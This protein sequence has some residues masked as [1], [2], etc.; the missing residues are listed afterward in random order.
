M[1]TTDLGDPFR[2]PASRYTMS[3]HR[4][5]AVCA[6]LSENH[7]T[8]TEDQAETARRRSAA[9]RS[10]APPRSSS[11]SSPA[12]SGSQFVIPD[13]QFTIAPRARCV[14]SSGPRADGAGKT[15]LRH[16]G[17]H[18]LCSL[19]GAPLFLLLFLPA[20]LADTCGTEP[21]CPAC[22]ADFALYDPVYEDDGVWEEEVTALEAMFTA[23]GWTWRP[24][25]PADINGG[26]LGT[27]D[28]R[29]YRALIA[30]GGY[31]YPRDRDISEAGEEAL[32]SFVSSGGNYVGFCAGTYWTADQVEWAET[33]TG[34][35]GTYNQASDYA[36]YPYHL[37]L[38]PGVARGP[39][40]WSPWMAGTNPSLEAYAIN[41]DNDTLSHIGMPPA[42]RF[43]YYG[44][45]VF[46]G[47]DP[48]PD[49]YEVWATAVKPAGTE[50]AASGGDGEPAIIRYTYGTG[51]V[52]LFSPHPEILI[53]SMVDQL[54][55]SSA[56]VEDDIEW[57]TGSQTQEEINLDSWNIVHAA[58][59]IAANEPVT[60]LTALP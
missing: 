22:V 40:G 36:A 56:V 50:P 25:G 34:G 46:A 33:A 55:L 47:L 28:A 43:F 8:P 18:A 30:P 2:L 11:P 23:F 32:R 31:A 52:I 12:S 26:G 59:Q 4:R 35:G 44:G 42:T 27:G 24:V 45:P 1:T 17:R 60:P 57:D 20:L 9:G 10:A 48:V 13:S 16:S 54:E 53:D 21:D 6:T 19:P 39:Y 49:N 15:M 58:L 14:P 41:T 29:K 7:R 5:N 3:S 51:T 38:L 37:N